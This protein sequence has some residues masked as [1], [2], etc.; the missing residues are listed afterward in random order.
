MCSYV[1]PDSLMPPVELLSCA[2]VA[3]DWNKA[4]VK[5]I[6]AIAEKKSVESVAKDIKE[7]K[8][9]MIVSITG[10]ECYEED[11][12]I[13]R[14]LKEQ[15]PAVVFVY[16]G[17]YAT[18]FPAETLTH[19]KC[20]YALFGEPE[21]A[22]DKLLKFL[23]GLNSFDSIQGIAYWRNGNIVVSGTAERVRDPDELPIP[24][25]DIIENN[26]AYYE[27]LI[28]KPYG[29]IQTIRGCPYSCTFCVKSYGSKI[30]QL[31]TSRIIQEMK[32]WKQHFNVEA[33]RFIDD[34][35]TINRN[36][37]I[38]L[39]K[40]I[41]NE[42]LNVKWVCLSRTDNLDKEM[43]HWMKKSGCIRIY[44][45]MESGSQRML[46]LYKKN[47]KVN[48]ALRAFELCREVGIETA[49]FFMG[50]YPNETEDDFKETIQFAQ[51]AQLNY[52]S[53]NPLTL[54][55]GTPLYNDLNQQV[56]F[57]L[58]PYR[59]EW[60]DSNIYEKFEKRKNR[61][62]KAFYF[63]PTFWIKSLPTAIRNFKEALSL[64][65]GLLRYI[66]WDKQFVISGLKGSK[67]K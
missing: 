5:L 40:A 16:F 10:F 32:I 18:V 13:F 31:S 58:Y 51:R 11:V 25:Y 22:L 55:P 24:A 17:H 23:S 41:I 57:S 56:R 8:P 43:L 26:R 65:W 36:R 63:R 42:Q 37:V 6:D 46:D 39:S 61:F 52:V 27:P 28:P 44:F 50:G 4:N 20:D 62:Y 47:V 66:L 1:A 21:I 30:G 19:S 49:A 59:N 53:Y 29:M 3:R 54:Y 9:D 2:G 14:Q 60:L 45:G 67:D 48:E 34:T 33:I 64:A 15:F 7:F 38:E 35:F 12:D